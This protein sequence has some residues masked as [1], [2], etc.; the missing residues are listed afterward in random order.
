MAVI[1][2]GLIGGS[3]AIDCKKKGLAKLV[4]GYG[5]NEG[6]LKKAVVL[7]VIDSYNLEIGRVVEEAD[8]VILA[9]PIGS[10][11]EM[12][13]KILSFL[14]PEAILT[15][16]GSVKGK[17]VQDLE[18]ILGKIKFVPAHP[19]AGREKSGVEAAIPG[20]FRGARCVLTPTA[21]TDR[22][23]LERIR[24]LWEEVGAV[25][26]ILN[27]A[28]HDE[29]LGMVSHLPHLVAYAM[30][31]TVFAM[32][33]DHKNL[34]SFSGGGFRDFSRIGASSP[35]MWKDIFMA[36]R[37]IV[38]AQIERYESV[39]SSLK[40]YIKRGNETALLREFEK[41]KKLRETLH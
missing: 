39:L 11:P 3:L 29:I 12:V 1:G 13:R 31:N 18:P 23:S 9:T 15:D 22:E 24:G 37:D 2:V 21:S 17:V 6:N 8:L 5:R 38:L 27:P 30:V 10:Y 32:A 40:E 41:S 36:N 7:G 19:I 25:V 14:S 28:E 4:V 16:V 33:Q 26:S 20:L 34:L 35:E